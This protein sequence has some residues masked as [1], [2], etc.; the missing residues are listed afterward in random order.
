MPNILVGFHESRLFDSTVKPGGYFRIVDDTF[1]IFGFELGCDHF[2]KKLNL[3]HPALKFTGEKEQNNSLNFLDVLVEKEGTG[4]LTS[5]YRKL[6]YT[7][8]YIRSNSSSPKTSKISLIKTLVDK[9]LMICSETKWGPELD[10]LKQLRIENGYPTDVILFCISQKLAS[11]AAEKLLGP[12]KCPV[13]LKLPWIG[14]V[15]SKF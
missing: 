6:T 11:L 4:F 8:Q 15:S 5:I 2:H 7:G 12:G 1:A 9:A 14:N 10:K 13:Y 3:L